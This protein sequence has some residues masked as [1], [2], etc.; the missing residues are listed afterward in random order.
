SSIVP[1]QPTEPA[2]LIA[3]AAPPPEQPAQPTPALPPPAEPPSPA[4][5]ATAPAQPPAPATA[6]A[7]NA[8]APADKKPTFI[9]PKAVPAADDLTQVSPPPLEVPAEL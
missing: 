9:P 4:T 7:E 5:P 8:D 1:V 2:P 3:Q 6:P